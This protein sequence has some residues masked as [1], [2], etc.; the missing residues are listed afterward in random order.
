MRFMIAASSLAILAACATSDAPVS[1]TSSVANPTAFDLAMDT[2]DTLLEAGNEQ[3]A[4]DRLTQLLGSPDLSDEDMAN[5]L[6]ARADIRYGYGNDVWGAIA[7]FEEVIERYPGSPQAI[8]AGPLLDLARGEATTLNGQVEMGNLSPTQEFEYRFRLGEH[9][10]AADLMLARNLTPENEYI[11][12]LYQMGY[13][14]DDPTITGP[15]YDMAE[16]D[17]T[18]RRVRFCEFGK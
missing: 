3:T 11:L 13:L 12:D 1:A 2:V 17:G 7:D 5:A 6:M 14:C 16:P 4:I 10:E 8:E 18:V 15:S 9:Q